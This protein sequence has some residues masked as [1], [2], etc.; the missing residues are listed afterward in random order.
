MR[1]SDFSSPTWRRLEAHLRSRLAGLR[2]RLEAL[3]IP[4]RE[5]DVIRGQILECNLLLHLPLS[6]AD[7]H[8]ESPSEFADEPQD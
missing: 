1:R 7:A 8:T 3:S 2:E 5:A 6:A 4:E